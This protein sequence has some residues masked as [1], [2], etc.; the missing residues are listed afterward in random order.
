MIK[1]KNMGQAKQNEIDKQMDKLNGKTLTMEIFLNS[2]G[3]YEYNIILGEAIMENSMDGGC[4][5]GSLHN[6]FEM[7]EQCVKDLITEK[8]KKDKSIGFFGKTQQEVLD[9]IENMEHYK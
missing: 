7:I 2:S 9:N 8:S 6:T 4:C 3:E 1:I 5:T